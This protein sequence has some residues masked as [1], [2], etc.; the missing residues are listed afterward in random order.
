MI[1]N[2]TQNV[3]TFEILWETKIM[4][5]LQNSIIN[6]ASNTKKIKR[7]HKKIKSEPVYEEQKSFSDGFQNFVL[8]PD[9]VIEFVDTIKSESNTWFHWEPIKPLKNTRDGSEDAISE[10]YIEDK[11]DNDEIYLNTNIGLDSIQFCIKDIET[12]KKI[13]FSCSEDMFYSQEKNETID[14]L[15]SKELQIP[16]SINN[17]IGLKEAKTNCIDDFG[18][19]N[20][21]SGFKSSIKESRINTL[22]KASDKNEAL[23]DIIQNSEHELINTFSENNIFRK[24]ESDKIITLDKNQSEVLDLDYSKAE[25]EGLFFSGNLEDV[26]LP[27]TDILEKDS[28]PNIVANKSERKKSNSNEKVILLKDEIGFERYKSSISDLEIINYDKLKSMWSSN[29]G[30][31]VLSAGTKNFESK[32]AA[33][34]DPLD[35]KENVILKE[36]LN[37]TKSVRFD[38][39]KK[40]TPSY[41][42]LKIR[43]SNGLNSLSSN[44]PISKSK[45]VNN[46]AANRK[47]KDMSF[48]SP[49]IL[50][51]SNS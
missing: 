14:D 25:K 35:V 27:Q 1:Q 29:L 12:D 24:L 51:K 39:G 26:I 30:K 20:L 50:P 3:N 41:K 46:S 34:A 33:S 44:S 6:K 10:T 43:S 2:D 13:S 36:E 7:S 47:R 23:L 19:N 40:N 5:Y 9:D 21:E 42:E 17:F 18:G 16:D 38:L 8:I 37:S 15:C 28:Y 32:L 48:V 22:A 45:G 11:K 4:P 31:S 49:F